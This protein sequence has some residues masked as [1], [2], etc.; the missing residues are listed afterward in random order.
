MSGWVGL[1]CL[2][3]E[4][5]RQAEVGLICQVRFGL[6]H[7]RYC[8]AEGRGGAMKGDENPVTGR[9]QCRIRAM[10]AKILPA[11]MR[12]N[13]YS[14]NPAWRISGMTRSPKYFNSSL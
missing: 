4:Q 9:E 12:K 1:R 13:V 11:A 6:G 14:R 3:I 2:E 10:R 5:F 7:K 8:T